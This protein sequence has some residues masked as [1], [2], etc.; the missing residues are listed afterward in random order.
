[1]MMRLD[2]RVAAMLEIA[3]RFP[4]TNNCQSVAG[5]ESLERNS[6]LYPMT[7]LAERKHK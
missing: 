4:S 5:A 3:L 2:E 6:A 1:M 7:A